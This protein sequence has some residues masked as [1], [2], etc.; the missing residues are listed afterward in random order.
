[1]DEQNKNQAVQELPQNQ[2]VPPTP[3]ISRPDSTIV[4]EVPEESQAIPKKSI[5]V[6]PT[7]I[8]LILVSVFA[9]YLLYQNMQLKKALK[10]NSFADCVN[11]NGGL[12][13]IQESY[14][15]VCVTKDGRRFVEEIETPTPTQMT[16]EEPE[17][18]PFPEEKEST[19][20]TPTESPIPIPQ[21]NSKQL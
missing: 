17:N 6:F 7:V 2:T 11:A 4:A 21:G 5:I 20:S 16:I 3:Q 8:L 18:M 13:L 9:G 15:R 14:P 1:M 10:I 19:S 12:N